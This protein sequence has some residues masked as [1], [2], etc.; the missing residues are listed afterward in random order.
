MPAFAE[1]RLQQ[2]HPHRQRVPLTSSCAFLRARITRRLAAAQTWTPRS[3][4]GRTSERAPQRHAATRLMLRFNV[5]PA[6]LRRC[7][8]RSLSFHNHRSFLFY[9]HRSLFSFPSP[10]QPSFD[11]TT[12][13][14]FDFTTIV[15]PPRVPQV[16]LQSRR[17][18]RLLS[19]QDLKRVPRRETKSR[20]LDNALA[21]NTPHPRRLIIVN[22]ARA[23]S[24]LARSS[25]S[26]SNKLQQQQQPVQM[27]IR[28]LHV[29]S[30]FLPRRTAAVA[31]SR[32]NSLLRLRATQ[33]QRHRN[34]A[35]KCTESDILHKFRF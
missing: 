30:S 34:H 35:C 4:A 14:L 3:C 21:C 23:A 9:N 13:I 11:F 20:A 18:S 2:R 27:R 24:P 17:R 29:R 32:V 33:Q 19:G 22:S 5:Y 1:L 28:R 8:H 26:V 10:L 7:N 31:F 15:S 16:P 6:I 25:L 12:I